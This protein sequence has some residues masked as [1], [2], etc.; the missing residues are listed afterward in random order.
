MAFVVRLA[1]AQSGQK[2][3]H[4]EIEDVVGTIQRSEFT[5]SQQQPAKQKLRTE[6]VQE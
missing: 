1:D 6:I 2:N 3:R 5:G 4:P